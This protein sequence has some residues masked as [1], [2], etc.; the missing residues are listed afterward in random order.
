MNF[1]KTQFKLSDL[2]DNYD[3]TQKLSFLI[4]TSNIVKVRHE[5]MAAL[6][7]DLQFQGCKVMS[8]FQKNITQIKS[9]LFITMV[10]YSLGIPHSYRFLI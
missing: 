2:P 1:I 3:L 9:R 8:I 4:V 10:P 5:S 6:S 7:S